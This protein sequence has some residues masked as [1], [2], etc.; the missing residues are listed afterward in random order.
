VGWF[1]SLDD[2]PGQDA[3]WIGRPVPQLEVRVV[4]AEGND[5]EVGELIC[6]SPSAMLGYYKDEARTDEV[7]R[8]GWLHT[9]DIVRQD[10]EGNLFFYDRA[11]DMI[12]TGGMNVSSQEVERALNQHPAV[13]MAAVV[14]LPDEKWSEAVT[15]FVV[16]RPGVEVT[17]EALLAHCR[18]QLAPFKLPKAVHLVEAL[19]R[20]TQGKILKRELRRA[21]VDQAVAGS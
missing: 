21:P 20:D 3:S 5:A 13:L 7:F 19:P 4:D 2:V 14:G 8:D 15:A 11:K 10:A 17:P 18:E 1:R 9:N 12:K 6:R 16:P